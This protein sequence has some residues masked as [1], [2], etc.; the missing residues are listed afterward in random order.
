MPSNGYRERV[1]IVV[2]GA[3][4]AGAPLAGLLARQGFDVLLLDRGKKGSDKLSTLYIHQTG[5]DHLRQWG[6]V[7]GNVLAGAPA[8]RE[9]RYRAER[10][11]L[12]GTGPTV[13]ADNA[14]FAPR[15]KH[16]DELL[17]LYAQRGGATVLYEASVTDLARQ[18]GR[19]SGVTFRHQ[20]RTHKVRARLVVG[21]DGMRSTVAGL[22]GAGTYLERPKLTCCYYGYFEGLDDPFTQWQ[23]GR[24]WVGVIPTSRAHLV[25]CYLPQDEFLRAKQDPRNVFNEA[26]GEVDADLQDRVAAAHQPERLIGMGDQ[27]NF[28]REAAGP[29]WVL[30]GDAG[31]HKDSLTARGITDAFTQ[32]AILSDELAQLTHADTCELDAATARFAQRRDE[33]LTPHYF[34]TLAVARLELTTTRLRMLAAITARTDLCD[35]YAAATAGVIDPDEFHESLRQQGVLT[36]A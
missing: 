16:L 27:Q 30:V 4:C 9:L 11:E 13:G 5:V 17:G 36:E 7:D 22:V 1:D 6:L 29:G 8:I 10:I 14:A 20:G 15:R 35:L 31:H 25:A 33:A 3:R 34:S 12:T 24:R 19:I 18:S 32:A 2:V 28:F 26:I 21:A 23:S